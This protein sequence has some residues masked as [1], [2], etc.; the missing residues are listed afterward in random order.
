[1]Q[2]EILQDAPKDVDNNVKRLLKAKRRQK[3]KPNVPRIPSEK[4]KRNRQIRLTDETY[5][6]LS[7]LGDLT[8]DYEDVVARILKFWEDNHE[9]KG[10]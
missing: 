3:E 8:E 6:K 7:K 5:L 4:P 2:I 10:R 9:R 1:L